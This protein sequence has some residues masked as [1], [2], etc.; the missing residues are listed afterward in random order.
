MKKSLQC[1]KWSL[2]ALSVGL[3]SGV[4]AEEKYDVMQFLEAVTL[5]ENGI[6]AREAGTEKEQS[7]ADYVMQQ[8]KAMGYAPQVHEF[9]HPVLNKKGVFLDSSNIIADVKGLSE[10]ML[11]LGAHFDSTG[12]KVGSQGAMDNGAGLSVMLTVAKKMSQEKKLPYTI[13]FIAFGAEEIGKVGSRAYVEMLKEDKPEELAKIVGMVN[14]DTVAGG[15]FL[16]VHSAHTTPYKCGGNND[17]YTSETQM[18]EAVLMASKEQLGDEAHKIHPEFPGYPEGVTGDWS[19]HESFACNG[20][21]IAY[22]ETTNFQINGK[23]GYD[24]Y[25]QSVNPGLW[26]CFDAESVTACDREKET[27]WGRIWHSG[28][29]QLIHLESVFPGRIESQLNANVKVLNA[30]F[31][32]ADKYLNVD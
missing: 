19:D 5:P 20:I 22:I 29:D 9:R 10:K 27:Q 11:V 12:S 15:D 1:F 21:P 6:G 26:D 13:R 16:Y 31:S 14:L 23:D 30:F 25:S 2:L 18:R 17:N 24:G 7:T 32:Q 3:S 8:F 28:N 4:A